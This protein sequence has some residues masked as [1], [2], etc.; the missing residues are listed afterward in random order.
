M[1]FSSCEVVPF[2]VKASKVTGLIWRLKGSSKR[3]HHDV[4]WGDGQGILSS[5]IL[6][7][8]PHSMTPVGNFTTLW[9][10][11][12]YCLLL[13]HSSRASSLSASALMAAGLC[14]WPSSAAICTASTDMWVAEK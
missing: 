9:Y 8:L 14:T 3:G 13:I 6:S 12:M 2:I 7:G 1:C 11:G 4:W 10:L 5:P